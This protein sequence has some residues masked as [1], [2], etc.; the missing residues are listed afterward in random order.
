MKSATSAGIACGRKDKIGKPSR[1]KAL[2]VYEPEATQEWRRFNEANHHCEPFTGA[3]SG[4][5]FEDADD[6][7]RIQRRRGD[8]RKR[9]RVLRELRRIE[10]GGSCLIARIEGVG[11]LM[12]LCGVDKRLRELL[13]LAG[14]QHE[15]SR[16]KISPNHTV[17]LS[18]HKHAIR[19]RWVSRAKRRGG[20]P[21]PHPPAPSPA[22]R[23][24]ARSDEIW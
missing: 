12:R 17:Y 13:I 5:R 10:R 14:V 21:Q 19:E 18:A 15:N 22:R 24:G 1:R 23:G 9:H 2:C 16:H 4:A 8:E 20:G 3:E 6:C 7:R 11:W